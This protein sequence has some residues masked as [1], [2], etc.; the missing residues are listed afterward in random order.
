VAGVTPATGA[1]EVS[2]HNFEGHD[3]MWIPV[4]IDPGSRE[5]FRRVK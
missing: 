5:Y 2:E 3:L 1:A 4:A